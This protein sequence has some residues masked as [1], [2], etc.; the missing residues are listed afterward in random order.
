M[1]DKIARHKWEILALVAIWFFLSLGFHGLPFA[2]SQNNMALPISPQKNTA[3]FLEAPSSRLHIPADGNHAVFQRVHYTD[4]L[5]NEHFS[6]SI[7]RLF[8]VSA[9]ERLAIGDEA[10]EPNSAYWLTDE[11]HPEQQGRHGPR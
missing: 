9:G 11:G 3:A 4:V 1:L 10:I 7:Y 2:S 6:G 8:V 5:G